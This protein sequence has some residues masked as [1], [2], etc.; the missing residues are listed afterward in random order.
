MNVLIVEDHPIFREIMQKIL[1]RWFVQATVV[2]ATDGTSA[3]RHLQ[4]QVF[5][6]LLL[7]LQLTDL[8]G[9]DVADAAMKIQPD[10]RIIA[11]TSQC[12]DYTIYQA[13]KRHVRGF[14]DKR[15]ST[16][17]NFHQAIA[18]VEA[19]MVYYS[20]SFQR[21]KAERL[22][23]PLSF[24]KILSDREIEILAL[25]AAPYNDSE[26]AVELG[27]SQGTAEKHRFNMLRKLGLATTT[28]L[29]RFARTRGIVRP[30]SQNY[31]VTPARWNSAT[32]VPAIV[33]RL[34]QDRLA[35][36]SPSSGGMPPITKAQHKRRPYGPEARVNWCEPQLPP[37]AAKLML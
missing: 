11:L 20:P 16:A 37:T 13:E 3:I 30:L 26:V 18:N 27:I 25:I 36:L 8:D 1:A 6:D 9:F 5:T 28:E 12:D 7:D 21:L 23:N 15:V 31:N 24:D 2:C 22:M 29:V 17:F 19:E 35:A 34:P 10:I 32:S 33:N 4:S 14:V